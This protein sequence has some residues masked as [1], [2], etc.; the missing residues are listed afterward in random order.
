MDRD[1]AST[2]SGDYRRKNEPRVGMSAARCSGRFLAKRLSS[3]AA[4]FLHVCGVSP[5][6]CNSDAY[7]R[8]GYV[9]VKVREEVES[10]TSTRPPLFALPSQLL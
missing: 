2:S 6:T 10:E 7:W 4:L 1:L 9:H 8:I 5:F 3:I